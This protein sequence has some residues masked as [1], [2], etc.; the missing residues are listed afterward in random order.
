M[1]VV[2]VGGGLGAA[3]RLS[4]SE[5]LPVAIMIVDAPELSRRSCRSWRS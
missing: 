3:A 1:A 4:L 2:A 5:E